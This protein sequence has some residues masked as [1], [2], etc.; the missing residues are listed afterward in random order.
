MN[1]E[2]I[3]EREQRIAKLEREI[4]IRERENAIT[5]KLLKLSEKGT[6]KADTSVYSL[7]QFSKELAALQGDRPDFH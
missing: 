1:R 4:S 3:D 2:V 5:A 7:E 6:E